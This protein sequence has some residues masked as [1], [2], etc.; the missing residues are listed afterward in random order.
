VSRGVL[1][2]LGAPL[3][4]AGC[5]GL[6][7]RDSAPPRDS[8]PTDTP[9]TYSLMNAAAC[10]ESSFR[11]PTGMV[12]VGDQDGDGLGELVVAGYERAS[13]LHGPI[14]GRSSWNIHPNLVGDADYTSLS[15]ID[16]GDQDGDGLTDLLLL[17]DDVAHLLLGPLTA[18]SSLSA[19]DG[20]LSV[21]VDDDL[22]WGHSPDLTGDS[23]A[24]LLVAYHEHNG[25]RGRVFLLAGPLTGSTALV[26]A[27]AVLEGAERLDHAG[28]D[29]DGDIG[30]V[31]G[32][33][34]GDLLIGAARGT[35]GDSGEGRA[36]LVS[37]PIT[38]AMDL[39]ASTATL[40]GDGS[41]ACRWTGVEVEGPGDL[42]QDGYAEVIVA[43]EGHAWVY[44][45]P[46]SGDT[47]SEAAVAT[48]DLDH[49]RDA[50]SMEGS[51]DLDQDGY[52]DLVC[53]D[54]TRAWI[55]AG[56]L[57]GTIH[58]EEHATVALVFPDEPYQQ[59]EISWSTD[60]TGDGVED[61]LFFDTEWGHP[62]D[63]GRNTHATIVVSGAE[64]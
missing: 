2:I 12:P 18:G 35:D 30:D 48:I 24:D 40:F 41:L 45:G 19:A 36:Y 22:R 60:L 50:P 62:D 59:L 32:D 9:A 47:N 13:L 53:A 14:W 54:G 29:L 42:D 39:G 11:Q 58:P 64:L 63:Y 15:A 37:G 16:P 25:R 49:G 7:A 23:Y 52:P 44:A 38:G 28:Y 10:V 17:G 26:D 4:C 34:F 3:L 46:L 43:N 27:A 1:L 31:D 6:G 5:P 20:L 8:A 51:H 21:D 33:G 61:L 57:S 56:P 55:L